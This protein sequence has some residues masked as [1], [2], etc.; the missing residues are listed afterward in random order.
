MITYAGTGIKLYGRTEIKT[1][2]SFIATKWISL[3]YLPIIPLGSYRVW[4]EID[5]LTMPGSTTMMLKNEKIEYKLFGTTKRL[6]LLKVKWHW[7]QIM[8]TYLIGII[9]FIIFVLVFSI[10][11]KE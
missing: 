4:P 5:S 10:V 1:D 8:I 11:P 3:L 2:G 6:K 7:K 9:L